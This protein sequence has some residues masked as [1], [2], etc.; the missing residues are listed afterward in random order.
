MSEASREVPQLVTPA[1][2]DV[3]LAGA[4]LGQD[5][6]EVAAGLLSARTAISVL[7]AP[8]GA[9]KTHTMAAFARAGPRVHRRPGDRRDL[10]HERGPGDGHRGPD[11]DV[12]H[13]PGPWL[14]PGRQHR[15]ADPPGAGMCWCWTRRPRSA[16]G[17]WPRC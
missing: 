3:A 9:G 15:P 11:R 13:R 6:A 10:V 16:P 7:V 12:Q 17:T 2:A 14:P 4:G 5:Q 1:Q 8:A